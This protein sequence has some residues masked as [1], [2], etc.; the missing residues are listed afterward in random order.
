M[1]SVIWLVVALVFFFLE[2]LTVGL[3]SIW[4]SGGAI[5]ALLLSFTG[6][7]FVWQMIVFVLTTFLLLYFTK[8]FAKKYVSK[9]NVKTNC[10]ELI[11]QTV[12]VT[13]RVDNLSATGA[14]YADGLT[15]TARSS[16]NDVT[17]EKDSLAVVEAISGVKLILSEQKSEHPEAQQNNH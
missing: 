14:A 5:C 7:G 11:G 4:V 17:F 16:R 1:D 6:A 13:E 9:Y 10:D 15:W 8:P 2:L 12:R 3:T